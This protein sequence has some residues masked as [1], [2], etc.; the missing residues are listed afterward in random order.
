MPSSQPHLPL[1]HSTTSHHPSRRSSHDSHH[2]TTSTSSVAAR[3]TVIPGTEGDGM[4]PLA[5]GVDTGPFEDEDG[6]EGVVGARRASSE[7]VATGGGGGEVKREDMDNNNNNASNGAPVAPRA[8][9]TAKKWQSVAKKK[10]G[11]VRRV[12]PMKHGAWAGSYSE[13]GVDPKRVEIPDLKTEVVAQVVDFCQHNAQFSVLRNVDVPPFLEAEQPSWAK[14]RWI[15]VNGLS[16]DVIKP[17][18]LKYDLHPL[19]I[20]DMLH[21]GSSSRRSKADYYK[22]HLF[23]SL[24]VHKTFSSDAEDSLKNILSSHGRSRPPSIL[25]QTGFTTSPDVEAN[26][27]VNYSD[28]EEEI[29]TM[30]PPDVDRESH[31]K[32]LGGLKDAFE[33]IE[34]PESENLEE[35]SLNANDGGMSKGG[36]RF[37]RLTQRQKDSKAGDLAERQAARYTVT[38]LTKDIKVHIHIEQLS[39]FVLRNGTVISFTQDPGF[40]SR[41]S[42]IFDRIHSPS[43]LIRESED[44]SF[45]LQA[46]LDVV[47]DH[48]LEIVEEF[49]DQITG[50]E[51]RVLSS[52]DMSDVR[53][54]HILSAQLLLL[55]STLSPIQ[56]LLSQLR[57]VDEAKSAAASKILPGAG[58]GAGGQEE[59]GRKYAFVSYDAK[60]YMGDVMDHIESVLGSLDL[61]SSLAENLIAYTFNNLSYS[62]N[63]Y[64]MALSVLSVIFLPLTFLSGYFGMNFNVFHHVIDEG[65]SVDYFWKI[66]IPVTIRLRTIVEGRTCSPAS[67][68]DL[69]AFV[70]T[71]DAERPGGGVKLAAVLEFVLGYHEYVRYETRFYALSKE[72]RGLSPT[73]FVVLSELKDE[74]QRSM[75]EGVTLEKPSRFTVSSTNSTPSTG[76]ALDDFPDVPS[77]FTPWTGETLPPVPRDSVAIPPPTASRD[78]TTLDPSSQ[79]L[80]P[81]MDTLVARHLSPNAVA[82]IDQLVPPELVSQALLE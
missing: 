21:H 36:S 37:K 15:H 51:S 27:K 43:D 39:I 1:P 25:E 80:R 59:G 68:A 14:A 34:S 62:S 30:P 72:E 18:A 44:H 65:N 82:S 46:L 23:V 58:G 57:L 75:R 35:R 55:K 42:K 77:R 64:M 52:P 78:S 38:A 26:V 8:G 53:H 45:I 20:E 5:V 67:V 48:A 7:T 40:H 79:P 56:Q 19:A 71:V 33:G 66:A 69:R 3:G 70:K 74:R 31:K 61:F 16:W 54:L 11:N 81:A 29:K 22:Q 73:P 63:S 60:I 41:F 24:V 12:L 28:D 76:F 2:P 47:A 4:G 13:P 49:R 50:L 17:I 9:G 32:Y 10:A 6:D